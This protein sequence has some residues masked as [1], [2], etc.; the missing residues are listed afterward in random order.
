M[1][2]ELETGSKRIETAFWAAN[3]RS[4]AALMPYYT[5]GYPDRRTSMDVVEAIAPFSDL[6]EL[7]VPF[8]DPIADGPTIQRS[9][10]IALQNGTTVAD[11]IMMVRELRTNRSVST[12]F[13]FMGYYNP[14]LAYGEKRFIRDLVESGV[15]GIIIPDLPVE[16]ADL[17]ASEASQAGI[18]LVYFLAPT[19]S[20]ERV[21]TITKIA[22][23]FIYLVSLTGVTGA[24]N[25]VDTNLS[26]FAEAIKRKA[27]VPISVGFGISTPEHVR[28]V[29]EYADGIIFGS[30]LIDVVDR[31]D[32]PAHSAAEFVQE[33]RAG[34]S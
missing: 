19:S 2:K 22:K 17:L 16:E 3:S 32:K 27:K 24:R 15:D 8:S 4:K 30:A 7:G 1:N 21:D 20:P 14:I 5:L 25:R 11:C 6:I 23:G 9:T 26:F 29:A 13:L 18:T 34:L 28:A 12:P 10:Q 31:A 33:M